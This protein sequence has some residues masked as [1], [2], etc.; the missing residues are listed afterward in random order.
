MNLLKSVFVSAFLL[1]LLSHATPTATLMYFGGYKSTQSEINRWTTSAVAQAGGSFEFVTFPYP[2]GASSSAASAVSEF[3]QEKID[4]LAEEIAANPSRQYV[5]VGHS[6]GC[7]IA[8]AV[9]DRVRQLVSGK[10]PNLEL[11]L[12]DG[13]LPSR[14]VR[15]VVSYKCVSAHNGSSK[16][17]N[18]TGMST[19]GAHFIDLPAPN[20]G[21][22]LWCLHF[23]IVNSAATA[24]TVQTIP[25]GYTNCKAN[26]S[27]L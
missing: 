5:V 4:Q 12:L 10:I 24:S 19:C 18:W 13:F 3:G 7:A 25:E 27:W 14:A 17:L 23:S 6:S 11:I 1:P 21:S 2:T 8:D 16:S 20:C 22:E 26:L 15:D 9:A